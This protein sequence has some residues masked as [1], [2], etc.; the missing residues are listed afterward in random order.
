[1]KEQIL[2]TAERY[3]HGDLQVRE[4]RMG[5]RYVC[6]QAENWLG[7]YLAQGRITL[8]QHD[9][10]MDFFRA[11][12]YGAERIHD[13]SVFDRLIE[14]GRRAPPMESIMDA[15]TAYDVQA[16]LLNNRGRRVFLV[17]LKVCCYDESANSTNEGSKNSRMGW[18][19]D[20]L[21]TLLAWH[22]AGRPE[23]KR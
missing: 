14:S 15:A 13:R 2:P 18:L 21:D 20:G 22:R 11:W 3:Q 4:T 5:G 1:M 6:D 9:A 8:E 17:T 23:D 16:R 12:W 19:M 10:G 7:K